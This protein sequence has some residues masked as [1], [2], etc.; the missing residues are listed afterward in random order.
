M[1]SLGL[2]L[3]FLAGIGVLYVGFRWHMAVGF[4]AAAIAGASSTAVTLWVLP[5]PSDM[6]W[7]TGFGIGM[8]L[9][10]PMRSLVLRL[11]GAG[12]QRKARTES[13]VGS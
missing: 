8:V 7:I 10:I 4:A 3:G 9:A 12:K 5:E 6:A 13:P 2:A 1:I 11:V